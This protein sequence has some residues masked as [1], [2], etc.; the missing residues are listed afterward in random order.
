MHDVLYNSRKMVVVRVVVVGV[1]VI[2]VV[3]LCHCSFSGALSS[4]L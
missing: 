4:V 1:V 3:V 2:V